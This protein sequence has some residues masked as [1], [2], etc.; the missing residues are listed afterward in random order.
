MLPK[1]MIFFSKNRKKIAEKKADYQR[2]NKKSRVLLKI[3]G[4]K[5][6]I[7]RAK[8]RFV[9]IFLKK[10]ADYQLKKKSRVLFKI[11]WKKNIFLK[12]LIFSQKMS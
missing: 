8:T 10:K 5:R 6:P 9:Q 3:F 1:N 7:T 2:K 12:I 4:K 11:F